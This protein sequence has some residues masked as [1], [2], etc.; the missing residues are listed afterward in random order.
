MGH[1]CRTAFLE[2]YEDVP[3]FAAGISAKPHAVLPPLLYSLIIN[4]SDGI[5]GWLSSVY[6]LN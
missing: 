4:K 5:L 2:L 3:K 1:V 6:L